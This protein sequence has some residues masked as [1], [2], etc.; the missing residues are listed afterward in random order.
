MY[1]PVPFADK[2]AVAAINR[3]LR[4]L[5]TSLWEV[6]WIHTSECDDGASSDK[7]DLV[8]TYLEYTIVLRSKQ[9]RGERVRLRNDRVFLLGAICVKMPWKN[10]LRG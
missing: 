5:A 1:R 10:C 8:L 2:S 6:Y 9:A 7:G 4:L 3:A